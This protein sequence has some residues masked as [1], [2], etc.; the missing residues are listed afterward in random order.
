MGMTRPAAMVTDSDAAEWANDPALMHLTMLKAIALVAERNTRLLAD[1][2]RTLG[3]LRG[4]LP[5]VDC[6][7][8]QDGTCT[9]ANCMKEQARA[10]LGEASR[11]E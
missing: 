9:E 2:E 1:R 7:W 10:L 6:P 8:E 4:L 5:A 11:D 3:L